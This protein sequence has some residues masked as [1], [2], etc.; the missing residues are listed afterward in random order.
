MFTSI[1]LPFFESIFDITTNLKLLE[2]SNMNHPV[3]K[4]LIFNAPGTYQHSIIVGNLAESAATK[5]GANPLLSRVSSYYHD[6]GKAFD[7]LYFI[8]NQSPNY[9][10]VHDNLNPRRSARIIIDHLKK[11]AEMA[12]KGRLGKDI[13]NILLQHHG[14]GL[15]K[16]FFNKE[17]ENKRKSGVEEQVDDRDFRY[18]GPKP[19]SLEAALVM[20]ADVAEASTRSL[21]RPTTESVREIVKKVCWS[22]LEDGQLDQSGLTLHTFHTIVDVYCSMLI[23]IHHHRIEYPE[24]DEKT[25]R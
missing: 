6:I 14:T 7:S 11:G 9:P 21:N 15:V 19:Q 20:L 2:L 24:S 12:D 17:K 23:S 16:Y 3:L 10:N 1:L 22:A 8:E 4:K 25:E 5:I 13:K 18:P